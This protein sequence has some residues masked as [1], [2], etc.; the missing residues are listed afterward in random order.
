MVVEKKNKPKEKLITQKVI[1]LM[2]L[3]DDLIV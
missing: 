3:N 1:S 2:I